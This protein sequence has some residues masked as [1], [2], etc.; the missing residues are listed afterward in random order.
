MTP[1]PRNDDALGRALETLYAYGVTA[2]YS[3]MVA[4]AAARLGLAPRFGHLARTSF[5]VEGRYNRCATRRNDV[6]GGNPPRLYRQA[7]SPWG[8]AASGCKLAVK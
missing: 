2:L 3:L 6:M 5:H 4:T 8:V 1:A 7:L